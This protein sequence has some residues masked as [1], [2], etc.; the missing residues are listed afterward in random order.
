MRSKRQ[1]YERIAPY[2]DLLDLPA[3]YFR[4]RKIRSQL[5]RGLEGRLLDAGVGT[6][7]NIEFYPENCDVVGIDFS[8]SMLERARKRQDH[9]GA[10]VELLEMDVLNMDFPDGEFDAAIST[11][12]FCV[13]D[14]D[15][16]LP[17]LCELKRVCRERGEIRLLEYSLP[18][19]PLHRLTM[20]YIWG[21]WVRRAYG[22]EFDRNT[23]QYCAAAGLRI[24]DRRFLYRDI[25]KMICL[26]R[27]D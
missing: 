19:A 18:Q 6:G 15:L 4:Y 16:Q 13:L 23:E 2:Y 9:S 24:V 14:D 7:R 11:F 3:E 22:A 20:K 27:S 25:I 17:A 8:P 1:I 10:N 26:R 12:L 21:P 5:V